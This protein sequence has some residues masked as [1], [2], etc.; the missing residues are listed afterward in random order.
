MHVKG[1]AALCLWMALGAWLPC[2]EGAAAAAREYVWIEGEKPASANFEY[3]VWGGEYA[4]I[5]SGEQWLNKVVGK[6][7]VAD[8]LKGEGLRLDYEFQVREPGDYQIWLRIGYEWSRAPVE[9]RIDET[10]WA[11]LPP[12]QF[13]TNLVRLSGNW[14][15]IGWARVG[16][17]HLEAGAHTIQLRVREPGKDGRVM[18]GLDCIGLVRGEWVPEMGLRPAETYDGPSD[19]RAREHVFRFPDFLPAEATARVEL[20]LDG[21]WQAARYDDTDMDTDTYRP[22]TL[23]PEPEDYPLR[24]MG[25]AVPGAARARRP[26]LAY[27]H[28]FFYRTRIEVPRELAGRGFRLHF[29]GTCWIVSVLVNGRFVGS[30]QGV[31]VPW[32]MDITDAL[33]PGRV[34]TLTIG[35]KGPYYSLDV[36]SGMG[37]KGRAPSIDHK[38]HGP[39]GGDFPRHLSF[40]APVYPS[41]K[42]EGDGLQQGLVNPVKLVVAGPCYTEDVFVKPGVSK[43]RLDADITVRNTTETRKDL[44]VKCQAVNKRTGEVEKT[45]EAQEVSVWPRRTE[46]VSVGG[47]W[48]DPELWWPAEDVDDKPTLYRLRTI[49]SLDGEPIDVHEQPFGFR[50]ITYD[51]RQFKL[52]GVPW[53]FWNW[54]G[55]GGAQNEDEWLEAYFAQNDRFHR[56]S[57]D[58]DRMW[59]YRERALEFFDR[60]GVPGRLSMCIDG[61]FI[62]L[63]PRNPL[64]WENFRRHVRQTVRAY[65]NHPSVMMWSIGNEYMLVT[66]RLVYGGRYRESEEEAAE[67]SRIAETLDPTRRSFQDG[68]G[69]LGGLIGMNCQHYSWRYSRGWPDWA[70]NYPIREGEAPVPRPVGN[71]PE[72]YAWD[73]QMPLIFGEVFYYAGNID[74]VTWVGG[75][76][77]YRGREKAERAAAHYM[78]ICAEGAR[79]Q[80]VTAICP[81]VGHLPGAEKSFA[82]RAVFVREHNR[83]FYPKSTFRRTIK[84][85]NDTRHDDPITLRWRLVLGERTVA[86]GERLYRLPP[87]QNRQ[88]H[89][90]AALPDADRR[91][92][93]RLE[94]ELLVNGESV[95]EDSRPVSLLPRPTG[96]TGLSG[97]ALCVYD[98]EGGIREWLRQVGQSF[99]A[100]EALQE[101]PD[102]ARV[103]LVGPHALDEGDRA[104]S[105]EV[106]REFITAGNVAIVLEQADPLQGDELPGADLKVDPQA[107]KRNRSADFPGPEPEAGRIAFPT[108]RAHRVVR[109]LESSDMFTWAGD[110]TNYRK[111]YSSVGATALSIVQAGHRLNLSPVVQLGTG[112]GACLLSQ[113][114]IGR[115]LGT[116]PV[117]DQL[118]Y[119]ALLWAEERVHAVSHRAAVYAAGDTALLDLLGAVRLQFT[120]VHEPAAALSEPV[121]VVRAT[122][123]ALQWLQGHRERVRQF[124]SEGGRLMLLGLTPDGIQS[125]NDLVGFRHRIRPTWRELVTLNERTD[126]VL[127]GITDRDVNMDGP[128][129]V[130]PWSGKH[131]KS[132][133][134]FSYVVD[135]REI[136][137]FGGAGD[138]EAEGV[139]RAENSI[140]MMTNGLTNEDDWHYIQYFDSEGASVTF[141]FGSPETITRIRI[142]PNPG[143]YYFLKDVAFV[144]GGDEENPVE[145]TCRQ[146]G[147]LQEVP[148]R[149]RRA[150]RVTL[151]MINHWPGD[152]GKNLMGVDLVEMYRELPE[153]PRMVFLTDPCGL[154]NY[155]IGE[156]GILLN[157]LDY[158]S[159]DTEENMARKR[160]T[161]ASLLR[162][163]GA[164]L[165]SE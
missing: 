138:G 88:D 36:K 163:M 94:L 59:G 158:T 50:V 156:G 41:T 48:E 3:E 146:V 96:A 160:S 136:A 75:P 134:V 164:A 24:W 141:D 145:F 13:T 104:Q 66:C 4:Q 33:K 47:V 86:D 8:E 21:L 58:S 102:A 154:V 103:L 89:I 98:P 115:K 142:K 137:S 139:M 19:R 42:G 56:I 74:R 77:V 26:E 39:C 38:R 16:K 93:G 106:L 108:A 135:G 100:L 132:D 128:D 14:C 120:K 162:N 63:A 62:T 121:A 67:L 165:G 23:V 110:G 92:N 133:R 155:P 119:N 124:C 27:G 126:P 68:G 35:V 147:G 53:H 44:G 72:L 10:G 144:F 87:G 51:G 55:I 150:R 40:V 105:V 5:L 20:P 17:R 34:N 101:L 125:F 91:Q 111:A 83:C 85:F 130:A 143:S 114:L 61:M 129:Q 80:G 76:E 113:M 73:G 6:K 97:E 109:G 22:L 149:P 32:E 153:E 9:W 31:L 148:M 12:D 45:F 71:R 81:W 152:S 37:G 118:L 60:N 127:L 64:V 15:K 157:Q 70:Y 117:A 112:D 123:S 90:E 79:W 69:D 95:F 43:R 84:V 2:A 99:T 140:Q 78:R 54:V 65:R 29:S 28:R 49:I 107:P 7:Q 151:R 82:A 161:Y 159:E 11:T 25:I 116:E 1:F 122:P 131:W 46:Q 18:L 30:H 52:N 57:Y